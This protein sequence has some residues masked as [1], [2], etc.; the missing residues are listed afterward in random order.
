MTANRNQNW[1]YT[2]R[3]FNFDIENENSQ[4]DLWELEVVPADSG[5]P[6]TTASPST[7]DLPTDGGAA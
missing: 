4:R 5:S 2:F 7:T 1:V 3:L 6:A